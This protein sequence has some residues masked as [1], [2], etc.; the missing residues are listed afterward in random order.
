MPANFIPSSTSASSIPGDLRLNGGD[1]R[2]KASKLVV[3][4]NLN[5]LAVGKLRLSWKRG[6]AGYLYSMLLRLIWNIEEVL[7]CSYGLAC[8]N[9]DGCWCLLMVESRD[10]DFLWLSRELAYEDKS[11]RCFITA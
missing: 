7:S 4:L 11:G 6:E 2:D 5:W 10:I 9:W 1:L 3:D 8:I